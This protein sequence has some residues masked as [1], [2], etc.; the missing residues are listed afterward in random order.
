M[1]Y[2]V[3]NQMLIQVKAGLLLLAMVVQSTQMLIL[4]G[5]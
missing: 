2:T 5:V 4:L 1:K 3:M